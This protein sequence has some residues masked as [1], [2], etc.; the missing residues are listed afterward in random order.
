MM[1][2]SR[3]DQDTRSPI[4]LS[5]VVPLF[6]EQENISLLWQEL[7]EVLERIEG[8]CETVW[9]DDAS[10]DG[11][12]RELERLANEKS[13]PHNCS[14]QLLRL[15][16]NRGQSAALSAG[17]HAARGQLI[18]TMDG[19][20]QND[21]ADI[22]K[23]LE[24]LTEEVDI[25]AGWRRQRRDRWLSRR[26]PSLIANWALR[27]ITRVPI[28][29]LGCSLR[30]MRREVIRRVPL[31]GERHRYLV[32][33]CVADGAVV[34]EVEVNHRPRRHGKSKYGM[35]R[36]PRVLLD[37]ITLSFFTRF[38]KR[39]LHMFGK[40]GL[41]TSGAGF[42]IC[43]YLTY[44]K[45]VMGRDIGGRP[46]LLLGVLL[47][48]LGAQFFC[49]GL[50][51]EIMVRIYEERKSLADDPIRVHRVIDPPALRAESKQ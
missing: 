42:L 23:L 45:L 41:L 50:L 25:V 18:V 51:A 27:K 16:S 38:W 4:R 31:Y 20:L 24:Y 39:P 13:L 12:F 43:L 7:F 44:L 9:V 36:M 29:D 34:T 2:L 46:L 8:F 32:P 22:P 48:V 19:D 14:V 3:T 11:T 17:F 37:A 30:V 47:L 15:T 33:L 49:F 6:N 5:V 10:T 40:A 1:E 35:S 26:L 21:P 28:H